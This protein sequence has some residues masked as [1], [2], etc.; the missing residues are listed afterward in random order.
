LQCQNGLNEPSI[1]FTVQLAHDA[2]KEIKVIYTDYRRPGNVSLIAH[3]GAHEIDLPSLLAFFQKQ[4]G[5]N[6]L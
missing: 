6:K 2:M 1:G 5:N 4:V 3:K